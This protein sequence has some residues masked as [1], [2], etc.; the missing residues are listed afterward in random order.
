MLCA[1]AQANE[2]QGR[3]DALA[4]LAALE[5]RQQQR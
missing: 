3:V 4:P 1:V 2:A 5:T